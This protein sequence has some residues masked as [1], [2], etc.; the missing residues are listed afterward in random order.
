MGI[1]KS[2]VTVGSLKQF[3]DSEKTY[4]QLCKMATSAGCK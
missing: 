2:S 4:T 1:L 3:L